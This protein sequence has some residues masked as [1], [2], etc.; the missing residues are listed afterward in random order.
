[1]KNYFIILVITLSSVLYSKE[2]FCNHSSKDVFIELTFTSHPPH[3]ERVFAKSCLD[4]TD[5]SCI[6]SLRMVAGIN[7]HIIKTSNGKGTLVNG[8]EEFFNEKFKK[9]FDYRFEINSQGRELKGV[10]Y[11]H[12][13]R[14]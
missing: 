9:C 4:I 1:M 12:P 11:S 5:K 8:G 2:H 13:P 6:T 14:K 7:A 3:A 10:W